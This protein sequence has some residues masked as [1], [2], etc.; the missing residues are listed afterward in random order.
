VKTLVTGGAGFV[1]SHL[2]E[3]LLQRGDEV[4]V[5]DNLRR[6]RPGQ[7]E[8]WAGRPGLTLLTADIRDYDAVLAATE[9]AEAVYHLAAQATVVGALEDMDYS[10]STNVLGTFNVLKAA[11]ACG[12]RRLVFTSSRE[13]Y[14]EQEAVPVREDAALLAKNPYG[15]SKVSGE[16]YCLAYRKMG[17]DVAVLRLVNLY[18]RGDSGRVIPRWLENARSGDDLQLFGGDQVLDF[19]S[20]GRA[21]QAILAAAVHPTNGPVNVGSGRGVNLVQLAHRIIDLTCSY[22]II[23]RLPARD[24]EVVRYVADVAR[25]RDV[26][27]IEPPDDPL[28]DLAEMAFVDVQTG[29]GTAARG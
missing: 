21:V 7:V 14:G 5:V 1:G 11:A 6:P 10:F 3:A 29:A 25:M 23:E 4:V 22:S 26:L 28:E 16:A 13:V 18:G 12:V 24:V 19:L 2:V 9:G 8:A 17:L 20:V 15:A 27:G